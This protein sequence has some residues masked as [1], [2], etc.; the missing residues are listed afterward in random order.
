[1]C[2]FSWSHVLILRIG[3]FPFCIA[4]DTQIDLSGPYSTGATK[5]SSNYHAGRQ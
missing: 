2:F 3:Q 4:D 5:A 1:M